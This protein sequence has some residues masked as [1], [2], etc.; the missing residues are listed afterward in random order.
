MVWCCEPPSQFIFLIL[1]G[2][3]LLPV[4]L[5]SIHLGLWMPRSS[6]KTRS[7][8]P[9]RKQGEWEIHIP[10]CMVQPHF[11]RTLSSFGAMCFRR[12]VPSPCLWLQRTI[13]LVEVNCLCLWFQCLIGLEKLRNIK[14]VLTL[15]SSAFDEYSCCLAW[16]FPFCVFI[17]ILL[18]HVKLI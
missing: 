1:S 5:N 2:P 11:P 10:V 8:H 13:S 15:A 9:A 17:I 18:V 14:I 3:A 6:L 12:C 4:H 7:P 16:I